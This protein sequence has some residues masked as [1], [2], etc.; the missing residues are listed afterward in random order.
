MQ[1]MIHV[2]CKIRPLTELD[3]AQ[4]HKVASGYATHYKYAVEYRAAEDCI[5][6]NL[7]LVILQQLYIKR[8]E[9]FDA[10]TLER[11]RVMLAAGYSF[12]AYAGEEM[13][14]FIIGGPQEWNR[15]LWVWEFHA[16]EP[17]RGQ[18]IGKQ[19]MG[20]VIEK[21]RGAG[22]RTIVCETQNTNVPAIQVYHKLGFR[23]E[24]LDISL[25]S[26]EDYPDGEIA[27]FMKRRL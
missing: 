22:F 7:R 12:A 11:Y 19:L 6:F 9:P 18:G 13:A 21:A 1:G 24:A 8:F 10:E 16:A 15:S 17:F 25:Y 14:G 26:N 4:L 23:M 3:P 2:M 20:H 27:I 5:S